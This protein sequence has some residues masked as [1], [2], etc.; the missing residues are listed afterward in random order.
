MAPMLRTSH[1]KSQQPE[2]TQRFASTTEARSF[3]YKLSYIDPSSGS[4]ELR[5]S[6]SPW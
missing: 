5:V 3:C 1:L 6:V 4:N 2:G